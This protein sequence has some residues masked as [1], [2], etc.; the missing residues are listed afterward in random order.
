M[1]A[2]GNSVKWEQECMKNVEWEVGFYYFRHNAIT[3]YFII[4]SCTEYGLDADLGNYK[5]HN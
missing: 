3:P 1:K 4:T 5:H 2:M